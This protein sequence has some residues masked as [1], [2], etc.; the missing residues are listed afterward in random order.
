[1]LFLI[2]GKDTGLSTNEESTEGACACYCEGT[3]RKT[4]LPWFLLMNE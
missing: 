1:L 2:G 3:T 4:G